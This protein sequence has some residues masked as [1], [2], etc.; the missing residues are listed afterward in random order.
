MNLRWTYQTI[1]YVRHWLEL[2]LCRKRT[3]LSPNWRSSNLYFWDLPFV[4]LIHFWT[5]L[6]KIGSTYSHMIITSASVP[7]SGVFLPLENGGHRF[8]T[9]NCCHSTPCNI[10][11]SMD[12]SGWNI[13]PRQFIRV[14]I[15]SNLRLK[16]CIREISTDVCRPNWKSTYA[17]RY[18]PP[19]L[20]RGQHIVPFPPVRMLQ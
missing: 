7:L 10:S 6:G 19:D 8:C 3:S 20:T 4:R 2:Y 12:M 9:Y 1:P 15:C 17:K 11:Q 13:V 14:S 5:H 18:I 16:P